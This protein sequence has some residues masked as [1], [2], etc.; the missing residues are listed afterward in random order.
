[1]KP[2][3]GEPARLEI[4]K[5]RASKQVEKEPLSLNVKF[6]RCLKQR[7]REKERERESEHEEASQ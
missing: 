4:D 6:Y 2:N 5:K 7:G 3:W 1:M